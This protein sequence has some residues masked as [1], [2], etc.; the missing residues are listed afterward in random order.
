MEFTVF[1][2]FSCILLAGFIVLVVYAGIKAIK[3]FIASSKSTAEDLE[4]LE[5]PIE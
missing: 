5:E 1:S 3:G 2:L 4:D